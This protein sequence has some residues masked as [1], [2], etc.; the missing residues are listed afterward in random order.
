MIMWGDCMDLQEF[1]YLLQEPLSF[2]IISSSDMKNKT[3]RTLLRGKSG[4]NEE[5]HVYVDDKRRFWLVV[6]PEK[7][8]EVKCASF[9]H[10]IGPTAKIADL[11]SF[12]DAGCR[13]VRDDLC[14]LYPDLCDYEFTRLLR[15]KGTELKFTEYKEQ[16][17]GYGAFFGIKVSGDWYDNAKVEID[18]Q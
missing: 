17:T 6:Y 8:L 9:V 1:E 4:N 7:C 10:M 5:W 15:V 12:S 11:F 2:G 14:E 3:P 16:R 18:T 13:H